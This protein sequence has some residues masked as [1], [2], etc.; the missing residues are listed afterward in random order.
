M[1]FDDAG[2]IFLS[3]VYF[4]LPCWSTLPENGLLHDGISPD[5]SDS[6]RR[7]CDDYGYTFTA[8]YGEDEL[9]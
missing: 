1:S 6:V 7:C 4:L 3:F 8:V 2:R 9:F 5:S